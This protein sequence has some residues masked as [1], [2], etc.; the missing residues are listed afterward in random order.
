[1]YSDKPI[2]FVLPWVDGSDL[3]WQK[4]FNKYTPK[5]KNLNTSSRFKDWDNLQYIFRAFE[6]F[7]PWV[8][9]IFF[10]AD[11]IIKLKTEIRTQ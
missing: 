5:N 4:E 2:D 3:K 11:G 8:N 6:E 7:T 1:M 9:K 10:L